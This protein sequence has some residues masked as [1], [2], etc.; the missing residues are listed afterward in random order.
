MP[1]PELG[2][3]AAD[4]PD[5][6]AMGTVRRRIVRGLGA[7]VTLQVFGSALNLVTL[8]VL[9]RL[10]SPRDF[11]LVAVASLVTG[12]AGTFGDFGL[13]PA[14]IQRKG[15]VEEALYTANTIRFALSFPL[16]GATFLIA[17]LAASF[18]SAPE[19]TDAIRVVAF[20]FFLNSTAF[21]PLTRLTKELRF[22]IILQAS[23]IA[24]ICSAATSIGL[25]YLGWGYWSIITASLLAAGVYAIVFAVRVPWRFSFPFHRPVARELIGYGKHLFVMNIFVFVI[26][27]V[28]SA[29]IAYTMGTVAI[30]FY[31]VAYKWA[32]VPVNFLSKVASQVMMPGYVLL[33]EA[34]DRL[35]RGY[36]E[37]VQMV[38]SVSL[39]TYTAVFLLAEPFVGFVL[40]PA[41]IPIVAP[42]R[43]LCLL[44]TLRGIAEPGGY[45]FLSIGR[46]RLISLTTGVHLA[47]LLAMLPV[48]LLWGMTGV[49]WA[50]VLAYGVNALL[51]QRYVAQIIGVGWRDIGRQLRALLV[52]AGGLAVAVLSVGTIPL[53]TP[54]AVLVQLGVGGLVY[55]VVLRIL[56]GNLY[57]RYLR[58]VLA[59]IRHV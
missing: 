41:W 34:S 56:A 44:G 11:G 59:A 53:P 24:A 27:N 54:L 8:V 57:G 13:G 30:G 10:L 43:V 16:F 31:A 17:P 36:L 40:G 26:L 29:A 42:L 20:L 18:F 51:I 33:R 55:L 32:N 3:T 28:D 5:E 47:A 22:G 7:M 23:A 6:R 50:V 35:K 2:P 48:A 1:T 45:L 21:L 15:S 19:A 14:V 12:L 52:S 25:A 49:A 9:A 4:R 37:T 39:P 46:S 38:S 58:Q